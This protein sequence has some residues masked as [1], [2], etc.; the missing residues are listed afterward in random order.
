MG[1]DAKYLVRLDADEREQLQAL[2]D[3]GRGSKSVRTRA[4]ILL[5]ADESEQGPAWPDPRVAEFAE[6]GLSTVHRVRQRFVEE[7][8]EA[9]VFRKPATGRQYRKLDGAAEARLVAEACSPPPKGRARW[10][11]KLLADR[12]VELEI[13]ES[14]G[15]TTVHETLKKTNSNRGKKNNG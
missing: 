6:A 11:L 1:K 3:E 9:A 10:T 13:V 8:F 5:K 12:L 7:G 4:R 14:I 15:T 2:V